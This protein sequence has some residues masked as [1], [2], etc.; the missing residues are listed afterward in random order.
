MWALPA[1]LLRHRDIVVVGASAGGIEALLALLSKLP[2]DLEAAVL[3]VVHR[4]PLRASSLDR[5]LG[6]RSLLPV[7]EP[8]GGEPVEP[9]TLYIAPRDHHMTVGAGA[10]RLDRGPKQHHT[11][12][13]V[14]PLFISA[15]DE[16]GPRVVGVLL[17]GAGEDGVSGM[18][19]I[20][21][22]GGIGLVQD[23]AE[24]LHASMP[25]SAILHDHVDGVL[26]VVEVARILAA[27]AAGQTEVSV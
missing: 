25:L 18:I 27:L 6:Y 11:R 9:C 16:Y 5:V 2:A 24:A 1:H 26:P 17:S 21:R 3:A 19:A 7:V 12:P 15:A 22:A 8:R 23:P 10:I 13:A 4:N 20:K 14:D